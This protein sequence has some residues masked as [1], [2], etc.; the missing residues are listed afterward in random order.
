[1]VHVWKEQSYRRW[2]KCSYSLHLYSNV[3]IENVSVQA[4][5]WHLGRN[6]SLFVT[7]FSV[8]CSKIVLSN[9]S[10]INR[11]AIKLGCG[12]RFTSN[13]NLNS[14]EP[15]TLDNHN[16][17]HNH[18]LFQGN[19]GEVTGGHGAI[20]MYIAYMHTRQQTANVW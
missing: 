10:I 3:I 17:I 5:I 11:R 7:L 16:S 2:A 20:Y 15:L 18:T 9:R 4:N 12:L 8:N 1:M 13:T 6:I 14:T 19:I